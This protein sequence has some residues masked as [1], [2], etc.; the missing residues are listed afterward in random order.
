MGIVV[1]TEANKRKRREST[2]RRHHIETRTMCSRNSSKVS[3]QRHNDKAGSNIRLAGIQG[4]GVCKFVSRRWSRIVLVESWGSRESTQQVFGFRACLPLA[5]ESRFRHFAQRVPAVNRVEVL[6]K[7]CL[8]L[9][10]IRLYRIS[11]SQMLS[12]LL[13]SLLRFLSH[14]SGML[15]QT[16]TC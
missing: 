1:A 11:D 15:N 16:A 14:G 3:V 10:P 5:Q 8:P 7:S 13:V 9:F 12:K 6:V 2:M 4:R